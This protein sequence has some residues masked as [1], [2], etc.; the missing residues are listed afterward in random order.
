[1]I[2]FSWQL[3]ADVVLWDLNDVL[4]TPYRILDTSLYDENDQCQELLLRFNQKKRVNAGMV[5]IVHELN[6]LGYEQHIASN[7]S[8][9]AFAFFTNPIKCSHLKELFCYIQLDK[10]VTY[11]YQNGRVLKKPNPEYF[12]AYLNKNSLATQ[13]TRFIFIDDKKANV[14][15]AQSVGMQALQFK[16]AQQLRKDLNTLGIPINMGYQ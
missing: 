15:A 13:T 4:I 11:I 7:I 1:M 5:S 2:I 10:S 14:E 6:M 12:Y 8:P 9:M 16:N 3:N